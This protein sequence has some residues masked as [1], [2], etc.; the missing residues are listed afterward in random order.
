MRRIEASSAL[1]LLTV[2][3][4]CSCVYD[5]G[6]PAGLEPPTVA[7][8][9]HELELHGD[10]RIDNY[11]WLN[12]RDNPDVRSYLNAENDYTEAMTAHTSSLQKHLAAE[13]KE[14]IKQDDESVPY[15]D[16]E[17][18]YYSRTEDEKDYPIYARK[19]GSLDA[20]EEILIDV[21]ELAAGHDGY[22]RV[23]G[24]QITEDDKLL[25]Y[26][27]DDVGRRI[28]T[29]YFKDLTT[30]TTSSETIENVTSNLAWAND[31]KTL[32]Y[33]RQD[34]GTLRFYQIWKHKLGSSPSE[35]ELVY[36][37]AD[38]T[39][40]CGVGKT[41][42]KR[43]IM[44]SCSQTLANEY[45][46][47]DADR[48]DDKFKVF[49]ERERGHEYDIDHFGDHFY[50]RTND[51]AKN[52]RL[53]HTPVDRT[54]MSNWT[55][56][57]PA[58][59]DVLLSGFQIFKDHLVVSERSEG[60]IQ[61]RIRPWDGSEEHYLNFGE[62]A[63][64]AF[65]RDNHEFDTA[66]LRF[67]Y[68]SLTTPDSIF[69]YDM[70]TRER[71]LMKEDEV[72]GGFEKNNYEAKRIFATARDGER[73][74]ISLV[75]RKGIKLDGGNPLL[76]GGYGSYGYSRD[77]SF[78]AFRISLLDRG[79]VYAIAHIRGGQEMGRRWYDDG[80]LLNKKN[81]FTDFIDCGQHLVDMK[82]TSPDRLVAQ[83]G[84]A[85]GLLIGAVVNMAP[86][87][88]RAAHAAVPF[89]DVVTT[90]LDDSI[91]LTTGEFDEWGDP[92]TKEYYDYIKTYSPYDNVSAQEYPA[93]LVTTGFH[94]S[95]VQYFEPAKWVAKLRA[96]KSGDSTLLLKTEM[97]AGHGGAAARDKRYIQTAFEYAF[98]LDQVGISK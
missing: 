57:I 94:D 51:A 38:D 88:F 68:E 78:S 61:L 48:P 37:E 43:Y 44:I 49:L 73:I 42:S 32:F 92:K 27:V 64:L 97:E 84:S 52:F 72:L 18:F 21:N 85:G 65:P 80:K 12:Q 9:P 6:P 8:V 29:V 96:T 13:F 19:K 70:N 56:V 34:P 31:H 30:G 23:G 71:T 5:D 98:L 28:Y 1:F 95:Q 26:G 90:M 83:G 40:G 67:H 86:E 45:R 54:A 24:M 55:E 79:M 41:Q 2:L 58:R 16:G 10:V 74:P 17:Y 66:T 33:T 53:M 14:R 35:D 11:Y 63:Y 25:A 89:V 81:T 75:H 91:P 47:V 7:A 20:A 82:Y 15:R 3:V 39:F 4:A 87:L 77:A 22:F 50:I 46:Y 60:L 76:L 36:E 62:P 93:L 69:D 59:E